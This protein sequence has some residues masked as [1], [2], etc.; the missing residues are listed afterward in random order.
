MHFNPENENDPLVNIPQIETAC[1]GSCVYIHSCM[2]VFHLTHR[3][4]PSSSQV[5][6]EV[7]TESVEK[8]RKKM[9]L[10]IQKEI[11]KKCDLLKELGYPP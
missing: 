3:L 7:N 8:W 11:Y 10:D 2:D 4:E 1:G 5:R 6:R 9:P